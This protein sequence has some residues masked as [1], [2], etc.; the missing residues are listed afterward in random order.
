MTILASKLINLPVAAVQQSRKV[1]KIA[2]ILVYPDGAN[3]IGLEL[4]HLPLAHSKVLSS[5]DVKS[6][7]DEVVLIENEDLLIEPDEILRAREIADHNY[8]L[9]GLPV[10]SQDGTK[11]GKITDYLI[12]VDVCQVTDFHVGGLMKQN[13]IINFKQVQELTW[14]RLLVSGQGKCQNQAR[15]EAELAVE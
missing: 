8:N 6:I 7:D 15:V 13:R 10:V 2:S 1:G 11:I 14:K 4:K 5:S 12:N 3:W 9:I